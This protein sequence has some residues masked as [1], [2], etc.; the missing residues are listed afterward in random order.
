MYRG[1]VAHFDLNKTQHINV[2]GGV[3]GTV[4]DEDSPDRASNLRTG[5]SDPA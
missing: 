1:V 3:D 2:T 5:G 4:S